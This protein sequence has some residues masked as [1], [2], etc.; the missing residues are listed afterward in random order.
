VWFSVLEE[1]GLNVR[2]AE[3]GPSGSSFVPP[4]EIR[5]LRLCTRQRVRL[6]RDRTRYIIG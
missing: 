5:A 4:L 2:P 3:P 6:V 1:A